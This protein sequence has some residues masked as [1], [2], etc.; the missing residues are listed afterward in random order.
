MKFLLFNNWFDFI[1][2]ALIIINCISITILAKNNL[3]GKKYDDNSTSKPLTKIELFKNTIII[4]S[5]A[6][7]ML[8]IVIIIWKDKSNHSFI[9]NAIYYIS[10]IFIT[11]NLRHKNINDLT[12]DNKIAYIQL[13]FLFLI[14]FSSKSTK[15]YISTPLYIS[16]N[17]KEYLLLLFITVK[18]LFFI[19]S[20]IINISILLSN[21]LISFKDQLNL[22]KIKLKKIQSID[23]NSNIFY[24]FYLSE[25]VSKKL[26]P[27]DIIIFI[28]STPCLIIVNCILNIIHVISNFFIKQILKT[29]KIINIYLNNSSKIISKAMKISTI[30][31][32]SLVYIIAAYNQKT[33]SSSTKDIYNLFSTVI[34]IPLI[35]DN[36]K[37]N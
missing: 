26:I 32:L 11:F 16:H 23:I 22:I 8:F 24:N 34:L 30:I 27:L 4:I 33:I 14:F 19:F 36:I 1:I 31:S 10:F 6:I 18:L 7:I 3:K 13:T 17:I 15:I 20:F 9:I 21:L 12:F 25:K 5:F 37:S 2:S 35:Y 29:Y 28:I